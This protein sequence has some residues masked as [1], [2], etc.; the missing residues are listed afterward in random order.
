MPLCWSQLK[1][2]SFLLNQWDTVTH[3]VKAS[4]QCSTEPEGIGQT[5][6]KLFRNQ[7]SEPAE[8]RDVPPQQQWELRLYFQ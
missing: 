4:V 8:K 3:T 7:F 2:Q 6:T 1:V 5:E